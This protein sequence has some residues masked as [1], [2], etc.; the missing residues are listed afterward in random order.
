MKCSKGVFGAGQACQAMGS[1]YHD[2]CFTCAACSE[3]A[4]E[5]RVARGVQ[6]KEGWAERA[7]FVVHREAGHVLSSTSLRP[8]RV[9]TYTGYQALPG[10]DFGDQ[11]V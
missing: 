8:V 3:Y 1:L 7:S 5:G 2:T 4:G 9:R 11:C 10:V 6:A